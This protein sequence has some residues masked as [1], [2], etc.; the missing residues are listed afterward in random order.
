M[1]DSNLYISD[2]TT[3]P[4]S[5]ALARMVAAEMVQNREIPN[6]EAVRK[7]IVALTGGRLN[8]SALT[9]Q[10]EMKAWYAEEF[11]PTYHAMGSLPEDSG[12][13]AEVRNIFQASFQTMVV[14]LFAAAK[15]GFQTERDDFQR[16]I[17]EADKVVQDLQR[18]AGEHELRAAEAQERYQVE[19][20][21]H[22]GAKERVEALASE[23]RGLNAKLHAA[24][25]QQATHEAELKEV[26]Q[27]ERTR[28]D[29]QIEEAFREGRRHLLELDALRQR[30][31]SMELSLAGQQGENRRL[32]LEHAKSAAETSALQTELTN[33]RAAHA[34]EVER[35]T[36]ALRAAQAGA[37]QG[38]RMKPTV[39]PTVRKATAAGAPA[40]RVRR[41]LHK[42]TRP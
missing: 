37:A 27:S 15:A 28:A 26:R 14:Q 3:P 1:T 40:V 19:A 32:V 35:M 36:A 33:T 23:V 42:P 34:K 30:V 9:M 18:V 2:D 38:E 16:Q 24:H 29:T 21:E 4:N 22:A 17:D 25:E 11:W 12:V 5:R 31:K 10:Q 39:R 7:R 6:S 13:P 20:H 41:S 8:P